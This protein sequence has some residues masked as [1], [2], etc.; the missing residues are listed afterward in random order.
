VELQFDNSALHRDGDGVGSVI[1]PELLQDV[2]HA[3]LDR[4]FRD[5]QLR[6]D[7]LVRIPAGDQPQE[8]DLARGEEFLACVGRNLTASSGDIA[9]RPA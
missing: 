8:V 3:A 2:L 5:R 7:F 9:F 1:C 6:G 4:F